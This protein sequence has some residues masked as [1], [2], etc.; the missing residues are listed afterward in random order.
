MRMSRRSAWGSFTSA[1]VGVSA[2]MLVA[3]CSTSHKPPPP[4]AAPAVTSSVNHHVG[5]PLARPTTKPIDPSIA[6]D[7]IAL[8]VAWIALA[9]VPGNLSPLTPH[10]RLISA[11]RG[12]E[13]ILAAGQLTRYARLIAP[14]QIDG[15]L[16]DLNAGKF[17][18]TSAITK[19]PSAL[20]R[21]VTA[22][23]DLSDAN[24]VAELRRIQVT[25]Y[26]PATSATTSPTTSLVS[27][28]T[29]S[30]SISLAS[31][32]AS[33]PTTSLSGASTSAAAGEHIQLGLVFDDPS[34]KDG[35]RRERVLLDPIAV[36][37]NAK[38][39]LVFPS[40]FQGSASRATL[41]VITI[42][43]GA[44]PEQ[45][46]IVERCMRDLAAATAAPT[47]AAVNAPD[48]PGIARSLDSLAV[49]PLTRSTLLFLATETDAKLTGDAALVADAPTLAKLAD[50]IKQ[51]AASGAG[52]MSNAQFGWLLDST[53]IAELSA[54][55][56][57]EKLPP[58]LAAVVTTHAGEAG[59]HAGSLE[60]IT[61]GVQNREQFQAKLLAENL[62]Y[63]EDASPASRVRAFDWLRDQNHA[64]AGYDPLGSN[65]DR[66]AALDQVFSANPAP[67]N[68][69]PTA[70]GVK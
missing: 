23:F 67:T 39:G 6:N 4:L 56:N 30:P 16:A 15:F 46:A 50:R 52:P 36:G 69:A 64:P 1:C 58:E 17:G 42:G 31:S 41:A 2:L 63:L 34:A 29:T 54:M 20:P 49:P 25:I 24:T 37:E 19:T 28:A 51:K 53:C 32:P 43:A 9:K 70:G 33:S 35:P 60:E 62:V 7:A 14:D 12:G 8:D 47:T 57:A 48:W 22:V 5:A 45:A 59:R 13:P 66:R 61:R 38:I 10:A 3:G 21:D 26:R 11:S 18:Q 68:A 55:Q 27:S 65:K 40:Q 44:G